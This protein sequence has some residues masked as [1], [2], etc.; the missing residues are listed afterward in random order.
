M[1]KRILLLILMAVLVFGCDN[2]EQPEQIVVDEPVEEAPVEVVAPEPQEPAEEPIEQPAEQPEPQE[3]EKQVVLEKVEAPEYEDIFE[4][5]V[6]LDNFPVMFVARDND[7]KK[8]FNGLL[9]VGS[10]A[11]VTDVVA[12]QNVAAGV[13][14]G[15]RRPGYVISA[16]LDT[17]VEDIKAQNAIVIGNPCDNTAA[18]DLLGIKECDANLQRNRGLIRVFENNGYIQ[19]IVVGYDAKGTLA[20]SEYLKEYYMYD[21]SGLRHEVYY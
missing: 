15:I 17:Q 19:M 9:V 11:P 20:A 18:A 12:A 14:N 8:V 3:P 5:D 4:G 21:L 7:N 13:N 10:S 2:M 1:M 16:V 6:S